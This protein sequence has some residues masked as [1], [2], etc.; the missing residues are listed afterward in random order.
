L[1]RSVT[2]ERF[3]NITLRVRNQVHH[4]NERLS[5]VIYRL[6]PMVTRM[7][8]AWRFGERRG[9]R[10][11]NHT[12]HPLP[13]GLSRHRQAADRR[14]SKSSIRNSLSHFTAKGA[15]LYAEH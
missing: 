4:E 5:S 10:P 9:G 6:P 7:R 11:K 12:P 2:E 15:H 8:P 1:Y 13:R 3:S 14:T